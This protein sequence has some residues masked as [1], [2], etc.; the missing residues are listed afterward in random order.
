MCEIIIMFYLQPLKLAMSFEILS[1]KIIIAI[2]FLSLFSEIIYEIIIKL[3]VKP[4]NKL[5]TLHDN[6]NN[7]NND[8][9]IQNVSVKMPI[10]ERFFFYLQFFSYIYI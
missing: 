10:M 4:H 1:N 7:T 5:Y 2:L 6:N 9:M 8:N 3:C